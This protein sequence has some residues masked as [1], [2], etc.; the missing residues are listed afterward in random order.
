MG[1]RSTP[2]GNIDE[3]ADL[4][5]AIYIWSSHTISVQIGQVTTK[6]LLDIINI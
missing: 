3:V 2:V 6:L 4:G 5:Y 1:Y